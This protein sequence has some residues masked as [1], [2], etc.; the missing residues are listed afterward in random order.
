LQAVI[1]DAFPAS[2]SDK[3][4]QIGMVNRKNKLLTGVMARLLDG[5]DTLRKFLMK[6]FIMEGDTID[7][8]LAD[9]DRLEAFVRRAAVGVWHASCSCRMG[10][11]NDPM[12]VADNAGRVYGVQGLRVVDA[13]LFPVV[14]C[15]NTNFPTFMTAEKIS[16]M[17]LAGD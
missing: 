8:L 15:A 17:I 12:A 5:P 4:R 13:S 16:D 6:T 1:S 3:V 9:D 7:G 10:A 2:Y 14:P 11:E